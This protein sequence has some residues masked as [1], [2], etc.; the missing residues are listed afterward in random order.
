M[1]LEKGMLRRCCAGDG[2]GSAGTGVFADRFATGQQMSLAEA[3]ATILAPIQI[4]S[5]VTERVL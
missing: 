4:A 1:S 3:F 5:E 2:A